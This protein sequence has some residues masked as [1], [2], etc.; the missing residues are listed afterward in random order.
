MI[1]G[2][3]GTGGR[4][5]SQCAEA[6]TGSSG[7]IRSRIS[8]YRGWANWEGSILPETACA[9]VMKNFRYTV[10]NPTID[11]AR[12]IT[13]QMLIDDY[14]KQVRL[15][16]VYIIYTRMTNRMQCEAEIRKLLPIDDRGVCSDVRR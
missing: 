7:S 6:G 14:L 11:R 4:V 12:L 8:L 9:D 16:E 5:Q 3:Q 1:T 13:Q 15:D 2:R 10:Q